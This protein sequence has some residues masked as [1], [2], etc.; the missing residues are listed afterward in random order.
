MVSGLSNFSQIARTHN[1]Q[2]AENIRPV[3][4]VT[5][6]DIKAD[7]AGAGIGLATPAYAL[8]DSLKKLTPDGA[9][10]LAENMKDFMPEADTFERTK[11]VAGKILEES[12]LKAKGVKL[13]FIDNT[14]ESLNH[15]REIIETE[16]SQSHAFGRRLGSN[17][18]ETFKEG[19]NA[20][21]FPKANEI[22]V[23]SKNLYSS[24]YHELGHSMN[25]NGNWFTK[26]L[27]KSRAI[28]PFGVSLLAP[29][30][31]AVG[32]LH[33]VDKD[34]PQEQ[35]GKLEK[36]LDFISDNAG[37]LTLA[38]YIPMLA[39]EG[40]ASIRGLKAAAKHL[41]KDVLTKLGTNYLKAWSTYAGIAAAVSG[42]VALGIHVANKM[43][44]KKQA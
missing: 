6:Q 24:V 35:K 2:P 38:T 18:F 44:E 5:K 25:K 26:G 43:K 22:V 34:K 32:L 9:R 11:Q 39:E 33:K 37:K 8:Y 15:L 19:A 30:F 31:L 36:T 29:V 41:P 20:A 1:L 27:Q 7:L 21:F 12:G 42:G 3:K 28:T 16:A 4:K 13:N 10:D 14:P 23:N 17:Y 40:L